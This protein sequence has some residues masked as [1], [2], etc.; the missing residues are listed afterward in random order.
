MRRWCK[1]AR[2]VHKN[3]CGRGKGWGVWGVGH[4]HQLKKTVGW[5]RGKA[6]VESKGVTLNFPLYLYA[7]CRFPIFSLALLAI[8]VKIATISPDS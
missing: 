1:L 8:E 2:D 3:R 6:K 7:F 4:T 5:K